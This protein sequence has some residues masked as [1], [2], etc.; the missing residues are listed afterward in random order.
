MENVGYFSECQGGCKI[1]QQE[2]ATRFMKME[3]WFRAITGKGVKL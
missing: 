3:A 1:K 2:E